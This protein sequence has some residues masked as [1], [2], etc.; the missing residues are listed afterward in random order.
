L[1]H[2]WIVACRQA[3]F[4]AIY[5]PISLQRTEIDL[6]DISGYL[7]WLD[8]VCLNISMILTNWS[9]QDFEK[10]QTERRR[11]KSW[12]LE[13]ESMFQYTYSKHF[14]WWDH[15]TNTSKAKFKRLRV[16]DFMETFYRNATMN[17]FVARRIYEE[18]LSILK[19]ASTYHSSKL[20][21]GFKTQ[22]TDLCLLLYVA[23]LKKFNI[24]EA[25]LSL[26]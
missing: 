13:H 2:I 18:T 23:G 14:E 21:Q 16:L 3:Y 11:R 24:Y 22:P 15:V 1:S 10:I 17:W 7:K 26:L 19:K 4:F 8:L 5:F 20:V 9:N 12:P 25:N 6:D